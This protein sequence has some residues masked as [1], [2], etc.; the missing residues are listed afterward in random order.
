MPATD[1][2]AP[3]A[4]YQSAARQF[5][6]WSTLCAS[7]LSLT[8]FVEVDVD[9]PDVLLVERRRPTL[10]DYREVPARNAISEAGG[11]KPSES[12]AVWAR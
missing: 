9:D 12:V 3:A 8:Q 10:N 4:D 1:P 2:T 6:N 5:R 7:S 11:P